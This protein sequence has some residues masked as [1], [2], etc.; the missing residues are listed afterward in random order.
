MITQHASESVILFGADEPVEHGRVLQG[1]FAFGRVSQRRSPLRPAWG[2]GAMR[3]IAFI[4]RDEVWGTYNPEIS[5]LRV[6]EPPDAFRIRTKAVA[7]T[8]AVRYY[9]DIRAR[10]CADLQA[11]LELARDFRTN[12]TGSSILHPL[13]GR[14]GCPVEVEHVDGSKDRAEFPS[15]ISAY[16]PF[17]AVRALKHEFAPGA[18]VTARLEGDTFEMEDQRNWSDASF[19]TYVRPIGLPWPYELKAGEQ[20]EQRVSLTIEGETRTR[21]PATARGD[22]TVSIGGATGAMPSIGV[23]IPAAEAVASQ[24]HLSLLQ[25]LGPR[26]IVGEVSRQ[27]GHGRSEIALY[28]EIAAACRAE[29]HARGDDF[30]NRR[31]AAGSP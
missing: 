14:A 20:L 19:K 16:Q 21:A 23:E 13:E 28:R 12:R 5:A 17:F 2:C 8:A 1:R 27:L 25:A 9:A 15:R 24:S 3:A 18:F 31:R 7:P 29:L 22:T 11:R 4:V 26:V 10:R 6:H 30:G